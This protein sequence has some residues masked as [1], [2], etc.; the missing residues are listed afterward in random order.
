[1][2]LRVEILRANLVEL[3]AYLHMNYYEVLGVKNTATEEE[4][5]KVYRKLA[6]KHHP[7]Q[8]QNN[9]K[10]KERFISI[11]KA[12]ETLG[13][14]KKRKEYDKSLNDQQFFKKG[15]SKQPRTTTFNPEQMG[16]MGEFEQF[17]GFTKDGQK[18]TPTGKSS[19][20]DPLDPDQMFQRFFGKK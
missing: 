6:A 13:D 5:K 3:E 1:M 8:N 20:K 4:I 12:Y 18:I 19:K 16:K 7:D 15:S 11:S 10:A 2:L 9:P 17:F 14:T